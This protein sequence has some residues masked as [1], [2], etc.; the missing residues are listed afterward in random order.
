MRAEKQVTNNQ[1]GEN[2]MKTNLRR[3]ITAI[4]LAAFGLGTASAQTVINHAPSNTPGKKAPAKV[5]LEKINNNQ[6][7]FPRYFG[8][9]KRHVSTEPGFYLNDSHASDQQFSTCWLSFSGTTIR[10]FGSKGPA[11][12][13][14]DIYLD[15]ELVQTI[16]SYSPTHALGALLFERT[17]LRPGQHVITLVVRKERNSQAV[18]CITEIDY[19]ECEKPID[20]PGRMKQRME[21]EY[22]LIFADKKP[23]PDPSKWRPVQDVVQ[24]PEGGVSLKPGVLDDVF[25]RNIDYLNYAFS[26]PSYTDTKGWSEWLP[27]A[28][29]G[30]L[31]AG[32]ANT[33]RWGEREDM[34]KIVKTILDKIKKQMRRDGYYNYYSEADSFES[35]LRDW[36]S[37]RKNFDRLFWTK[38]LLAAGRAG[39]PEAYQLVR[40]FYDWFNASRYPR[41]ILKG[42]NSPNAFP[43]WPLVY[44]S[45]IGKTEDLVHAIRYCDQAYWIS[46]LSYRSPFAF[47]DYPWSKP[48]CYDLLGLEAYLDQYKATGDK[49]YLKAVTGGW[50][51][52]RQY[53]MHIGGSVAICEN[54]YYP[55]GSQY[56]RLHTGETCGSIFWINL[57]AAL[58]RLSPTEEKYPAEV[59]NSLYNVVMATQDDKG[60]I[61][62]HNHLENEKDRATCGNSCCETSTTGLI[63]NLPALIY[64]TAADGLYVHLFAASAIN[65]QVNGKNVVVETE[66][67]FPYASGVLLTVKEAADVTMKI[68]IRVPSWATGKIPVKVNGQ[69][70]TVGTPGFYATLD[71]NWRSNDKIE[72]DLPIGFRTVQY[73]GLDQAEGNLGRYALLWGPI[74]MALEAPVNGIPRIKAS[75]GKLPELLTPVAGKPLHYSVPGHPG[76]QY[77]PYWQV[78]N[79]T[80]T[81]FP[82]VQP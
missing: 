77:L 16:D 75:A 21:L 22:D 79:Q 34:Q 81:C 29:D 4:V 72:F 47:S 38:G 17:E 37:E 67:K 78:T 5:R 52:F 42:K 26:F 46:E 30:R 59:E 80:F 61:R 25:K 50:D 45:P 28:N 53:Y 36:P 35:N 8:N 13:L 54:A 24:V 65:W 55:P 27:A 49:M 64:S 12:G 51:A 44:N 33:L 3:R 57:N 2:D 74:L 63:G 82:I 6:S 11:H 58:M 56:L 60:L 70:L 1:E 43:S 15:G 73:T 40:R 20:V 9:W 68:C 41:D 76:V 10:V 19:L 39:Y 32:A 31:L 69:Q 62:Y 71:R 48:H 66:T 23:Q 14:S 7:P 18:G